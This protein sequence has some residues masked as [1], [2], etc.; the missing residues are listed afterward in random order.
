MADRRVDHLLIGGGIA[1]ATCAQALR[2]EGAT[3]SIL[4]VGRELDPPYHRPPITKGYLGGAEAKADTLIDVPGDVEVL[5]RT[6]VM[7]LDPAARTVTLSTKEA[8]EYDT[9]LLATGAMVRRLAVDGAQLEGIHYLRAL[10]NADALRR[11]AEGAEDVVCV[12]GSYIGCEVAATLAAQGRRVTVVL[13]EEEPLERG[14]GLQVGAWVRGRLE[15]HGVTVLAGVEVERFEGEGEDAE[16]VARIVLAGGRA[17]PAD[18]VVCGVGALPDV[19]LARKSGLELGPLGGVRTDARLAV[20]GV[21][22]LYAAG[23][24]CEYDSPVHGRV[25][26]IEHEEVAAAHGRTVAR[27]MLGAGV[28]HTEVP[29]FWSDLADWATLEYVGPAEGWD[30]EVVDGDPESGAFAVWYLRDGRVAA[31]LRAGGHGDLE[32]AKA[33]IAGGESVDADALAD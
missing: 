21:E 20:A 7:A 15:A 4:L 9:A 19:M 11:D 16:R 6:S 26:R 3:G 32:R 33:L 24:M 12:G 1:S 5:T 23:D 30:E 31:M 8:I 25:V 18:L 29:Y 14:F 28:E 17:L 10:G 13:Q 27:N 22:G 2:A